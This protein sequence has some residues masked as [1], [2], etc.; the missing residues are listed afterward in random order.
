MAGW[1][2]ILGG[3]AGGVAGFFVGGQSYL[4]YAIGA[5]IGGYLG[6]TLDKPPGQTFIGPRLNDLRIQSGGY[7]QMLPII[8]GSAMRV[9]GTVIFTPAAIKETGTFVTTDSGGQSVT[10]E[11]FVYSTSAAIALNDTA[12]KAI[13]GVRR[14]WA[15]GQLIANYSSSANLA[16]HSQS[17]SGASGMRVYFGT[18]TQAQDPY[19]LTAN[20]VESA[21]RGTAYVVILDLQ[22]A[23]Y[24]NRLPNLEFEVLNSGTV[25]D[26]T[27]YLDT[28]DLLGLAANGSIAPDGNLL[29]WN[30][31]SATVTRLT[32]R[33]PFT[34]QL[35]KNFYPEPFMGGWIVS[36]NSA[37]VMNYRGDIAFSDNADRIWIWPFAGTPVAVTIANACRTIVEQ[38]G[39][40]YIFARYQASP[41]LYGVLRVAPSQTAFTVLR[42]VATTPRDIWDGNDGYLYIAY[43]GAGTI[44]KLRRSDGVLIRSFTPSALPVSLCTAGDGSIWYLRGSNVQLWRIAADFSSE[45]LVFDSG[46]TYTGSGSERLSRDWATGDVIHASL[47]GIRRY[48]QD[49]T[50]GAV[51]TGVRGFAAYTHPNFP[52]RIYTFNQVQPFGGVTQYVAMLRSNDLTAGSVGLDAEVASL[53]KRVGYVDADLDVTQLAGDSLRGYAITQQDELRAMLTPLM[54]AYFFDMVE[55]N[56]KLKFVKRGGASIAT[57]LQADMGARIAD[58]QA[59]EPYNVTRMQETELPR[60]ITLSYYDVDRDYQISTVYARRQV[61]QSVND[62]SVNLALALTATEAQQ[63]VYKMLYEAWA[64]RTRFSFA[65]SQKY[66]HLEPTD[67]VDLALDEGTFT[68]RLIGKKEGQGVIQ[69]E[70]AGI[71]AALYTQTA[72]GDGGPGGQTDVTDTSATNLVLLDTALLAEQDDSYG[73]YMAAAGSG[74]GWIGGEVF[75]STDG[76]N[77][78]DTGLGFVTPATLGRALTVLP[79]FLGGN[80]FD[81]NSTVDVSVTSG[82]PVA[83]TD[84][85]VLNGANLAWLGGELI[86][87]TTAAFVSAN[88]YRLSGLLRGRLGTEW[89][90]GRHVSGEVFAVLDSYKSVPLPSTDIGVAVKYK[91]VTFGTSVAIATAQDFALASNRLKPFS[92]VG[93]GGGRNA[94][95]DITI[96][97]K[98]RARKNAD[99]SSGIDVPLDEPTEAYEVD[100]FAGTPL[101]LTAISLANPGVFTTSGV[102]GLAV[103]DVVYMRNIVGPTAFNDRSYTIVSVPTTSTFTARDRSGLIAVDASIYPAWVSGGS[104]YKLGRTIGAVTPTATYTAAQQTTDYGGT[105]ATVYVVAYQSSSRVG[106][107]YAGTGVI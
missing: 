23:K 53:C 36:A 4:G 41:A 78:S 43:G 26:T 58:S 27:G 37:P 49:G 52:A 39:N 25:A 19:L 74:G 30:E 38:V 67:V 73:L 89:A 100:V 34:L 87:F 24:G 40:F 98:R 71:D 90:M 50:P 64:S 81:R 47:G 56:N 8:K 15:D 33:D 59:T 95:G 62:V 16:V 60:Q 86:Q 3:L 10:T 82:A 14:I 6:G 106:R 105:Q 96:N 104:V 13:V 102:H 51:T 63:I 97:W 21:Y 31:V 79:D 5:A 32:L 77:Y 22:L 12:D 66:A 35:I 93:I 88:V 48:S 107:G 72:V 85:A 103:N 57:V 7:G 68:V 76:A 92:P 55:S 17:L 83:A 54:T 70:A 1:G 99:W 28:H 91:G 45:A 94:A 9:A 18:E 69:F 11:T 61:M 44:E 84:L 80:V 42:Q 75:K 20:P 29:V 2:A 65:L 46:S 101:T